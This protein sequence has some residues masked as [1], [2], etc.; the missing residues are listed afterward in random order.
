MLG[1]TLE[2][3]REIME[4]Y[5]ADITQGVLTQDYD[6]F[7]PWFTFPYDVHCFEGSAR[8]ETDADLRAMFE[9]A[10]A[11]Y[12]RS[13][14][15]DLIRVIREL[16]FPA[17]DRLHCLYET[18]EICGRD[19]LAGEPFFCLTEL[20]QDEGGRWQVRRGEYD[21]YP[22]DAKHHV[23]IDTGRPLPARSR[24]S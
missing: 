12:I 11:Y 16:S 4:R 3:A 7:R 2:S 1:A 15:T 9:R 19:T 22:T 13:G 21:L 5:L 14:V 6:L 8:C 10:C 17:P 24:T 20:V 18:R 23:L